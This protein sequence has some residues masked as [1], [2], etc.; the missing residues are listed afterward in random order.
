MDKDQKS[1]EKKN[2][3][4][5]HATEVN[6]VSAVIIA[7]AT[8]VLAFLTSRYLKE[9]KSQRLAAQRSIELTEK[10]F[11]FE[12]SAQPYIKDIQIEWEPDSA[13]MQLKGRTHIKLAN[14]GRS[15]ARNIKLNR[16]LEKLKKSEDEESEQ[17]NRVLGLL[18]YLYPGQE[19]SV[20]M[21]P[22]YIDCSPERMDELEKLKESGSKIGPKIPNDKQDR[23]TLEIELLYDDSEG[24]PHTV[25]YRFE[26]NYRLNKWV[27]AGFGFE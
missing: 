9:T 7:V 1:E 27:P 3:M 18:E 21:T 20:S 12:S 15:A 6:A 23:L 5:R 24:N 8:I 16:L 26:Y 2:W 14:C 13:K 4:E 17:Q 19:P 10:A 25:P 22:I 11:E